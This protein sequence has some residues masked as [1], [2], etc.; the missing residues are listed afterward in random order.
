[1]DTYEPLEA[2]ASFLER[3][4]QFGFE[5]PEE[6]LAL[7]GDFLG[8]LHA[9]NQQ[10]NLTGAREAEELWLRHAFDSLTLFPFVAG[11]GSLVDIGSGGGFPAI[12]LAI[13]CPDLQITMIESTGKKC[14]FLKACIENL[15]LDNAKVRQG[16]AETLAHEPALREAFDVGTARGLAALPTLLEYL[17][18][19]VQPAGV[20]LAMKGRR[21][22]EELE[23][24]QNALKLLGA[25][26][27]VVHTVDE[28]GDMVILEI[29]KDRSTPDKYPRETG[30]PKKFPL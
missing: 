9:V 15:E 3:C 29:P 21:H 30:I 23:A 24:A 27:P 10:M 26:E 2:P 5:M 19:F 14:E 8:F 4:E 11:A 13:A 25:D 20:V 28:E 12:V 1:M 18:P 22:A 17:M 16:R 7:L 6:T